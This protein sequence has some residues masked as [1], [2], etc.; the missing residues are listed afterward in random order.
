MGNDCD[1]EP[2]AGMVDVGV[3]L[4]GLVVMS[5]ITPHTFS[6]T[7]DPQASRILSHNRHYKCMWV[8]LIDSRYEIVRGFVGGGVCEG[9]KCVG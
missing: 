9:I 6:L 3:R 7:I 2:R 1:V 8:V 5:Y 4:D